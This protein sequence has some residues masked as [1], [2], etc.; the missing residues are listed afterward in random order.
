M[1]R[2]HFIQPVVMLVI[3]LSGVGRFSRGVRNVDVLGLFASG[4]LA[5]TSI[6]RVITAWKDRR[7]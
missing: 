4:M 6:T 5:G 7:G 3:A 1:Q 2:K